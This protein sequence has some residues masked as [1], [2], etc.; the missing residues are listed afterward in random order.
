LI[1][2]FSIKNKFLEGINHS[3]G[4]LD[5]YDSLQPPQSHEAQPNIEAFARVPRQSSGMHEHKFSET[6][7]FIADVIVMVSIPDVVALK[8]MFLA[9]IGLTSL[10]SIVEM[11]LESH[12]CQS[13]GLH[14]VNGTSIWRHVN[15]LAEIKGFIG[16]VGI[17]S[18]L[19]GASPAVSVLHPG[20]VVVVL[21]LEVNLG[22]LY[23]HLVN[24][25]LPSV[26]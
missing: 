8:V 22:R 16:T 11:L 3:L 20:L 17:D 10:R 2:H 26:S 15:P 12:P 7:N 24:N 6:P 9:I 23:S 4:V 21:D 5:K 18:D 1:S 14:I 19:S 13:V 25:F